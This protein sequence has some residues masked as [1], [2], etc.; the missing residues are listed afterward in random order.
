MQK[1]QR[2]VQ[3]K[4]DAGVKLLF[5]PITSLLDVRVAFV[6]YISDT[7][8]SLRGGCSKGEGNYSPSHAPSRS[9]ALK[10]PLPPLT[11]ATQAILLSKTYRNSKKRDFPFLA[12]IKTA[13][14]IS[15]RDLSLSLLLR[16]IRWIRDSLRSRRRLL[17][18][19]NQG[20]RLVI[21]KVCKIRRK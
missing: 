17:R 10:F 6:A 19:L 18:R 20:V 15:P 1:R 13:R 16:M 14:F 5:K 8:V 3:K 12:K 2:N 4:Y 7:L 9:R 11:P 21:S